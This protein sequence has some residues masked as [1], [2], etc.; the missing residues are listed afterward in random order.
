MTKLLEYLPSGGLL[1][2]MHTLLANS[3]LSPEWSGCPRHLLTREQAGPAAL[4]LATVTGKTGYAPG[5]IT[6]ATYYLPQTVL[7]C[8]VSKPVC[9]VLGAGSM[10]SSCGG[11]C[12]ADEGPRD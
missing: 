7:V 2:L 3:P 6:K 4:N 10:S 11:P 9:P 12:A 5:F 8:C 1:P